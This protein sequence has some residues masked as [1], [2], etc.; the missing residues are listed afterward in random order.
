MTA[1]DEAALNTFVGKMLDD[2]LAIGQ[3]YAE[4]LV[5][6]DIA[7]L[8][9]DATAELRDRLIGSAGRTTKFDQRHSAD[10]GDL[11]LDQISLELT[12][13]ADPHRCLK[14]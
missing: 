7:M 13:D 8:P 2:L 14:V 9:L 10:A 3:I 4:G 6:C 11:A 1:I 12:H 5:A